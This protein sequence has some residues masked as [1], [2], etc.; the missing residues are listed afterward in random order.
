[1]H[2]VALYKKILYLLGRV[3]TLNI[4]DENVGKKYIWA[5]VEGGTCWAGFGVEKIK[6]DG[7]YGCLCFFQFYTGGLVALK[8]VENAL[9]LL[10]PSSPKPIVKLDIILV[11][12]LNFQSTRMR[13]I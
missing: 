13:I 1:M 12:N 8:K 7:W 4:D 3:S 9:G 5:V 11:G 6:A 10:S 2:V